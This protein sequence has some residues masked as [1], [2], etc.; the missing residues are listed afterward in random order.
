MLSSEEG[1]F[2]KHT[3]PGQQQPLV[4]ASFEE[5][6]FKK[7]QI[8]FDAVFALKSVDF[9]SKRGSMRKVRYPLSKCFVFF[10]KSPEFLMSTK[11]WTHTSMQT[12]E[13]I[14]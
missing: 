8:P 7:V 10:V 11:F 13:K 3:R 6:F 9:L 4:F 1:H 2:P 5:V 12:I 14:A